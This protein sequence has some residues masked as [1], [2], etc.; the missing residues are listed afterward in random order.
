MRSDGQLR[1]IV[2]R[3]NTR[4]KSLKSRQG[5]GFEKILFWSFILAFTLLIIVQAALT[6]PSVRTSLSMVD[7]LEGRP[8]GAEEYLYK[9]G[10]IMLQLL[11]T[12]NNP[13]IKVLINGEETGAFVS[14]ILEVTVKE[15][16]VV[17]IDGS[18]VQEEAEV[19]IVSANDN[20]NPQCI[21]KRVAVNSN[22]KRLAI[23][24][25]K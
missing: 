16:D 3:V 17:E 19:A 2:Y 23:I 5:F 8:L 4:R 13:K 12:E 24:T 20:V 22:I 10:A 6:N 21:N 14:S 7:E 18:R 15:G 1:L 9:E 11:S 25:M